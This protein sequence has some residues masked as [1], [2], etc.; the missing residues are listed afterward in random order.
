MSPRLVR[1]RR[2]GSPNAGPSPRTRLS[3][4]AAHLQWP[5]CPPGV[6]RGLECPLLSGLPSPSS[7]ALPR[8]RLPSSPPSLSK[9]PSSPQ[10]LPQ[11]SVRARPFEDTAEPQESPTQPCCSPGDP[12]HVP[13]AGAGG[14]SLCP[15]PPHLPPGTRP[16]HPRPGQPQ[17]PSNTEP[18]PPE[19]QTQPRP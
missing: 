11:S 14:L 12:C 13:T 3:R 4:L 2:P 8:A 19:A 10:T 15:E 18:Q 5:R 6:G 1:R 17:P 9:P 16:T 7:L